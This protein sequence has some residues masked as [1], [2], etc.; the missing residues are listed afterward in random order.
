MDFKKQGHCVYYSRYHLVFVT[1]YRRKVLK[2][3]MGIFLKIKIKEVEKLYPDLAILESNTD[4]DHV[5]IL[6]SIPPKISVSK[7]VNII[8]SNTGKSMRKKF[9][10][11]DKVYW[12]EDGIWSGEYFMSTVGVNESIIR[13]YIEHQGREDSGQAELEFS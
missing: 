8:K 13:K 2:R 7:V 10:F 6:M 11:L 4:D 9:P 3:G 1:K 5:H 12:E